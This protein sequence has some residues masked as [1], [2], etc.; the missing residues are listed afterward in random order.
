MPRLFFF[1]PVSLPHRCAAT[2]LMCDI[3]TGKVWN[4]DDK[5]AVGG[6]KEEKNPSDEKPIYHVSTAQ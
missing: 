6:G 1:H 4:Y 5:N 2:I 3:L